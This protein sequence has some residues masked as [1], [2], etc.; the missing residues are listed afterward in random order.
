MSSVWALG[1]TVV[2][3]LSKAGQTGLNLAE[4]PDVVVNFP[5]PVQWEA[6][7]RLAPLTG[8]DPVPE[9][10]RDRCRFGPDKVAAACLTPQ[11]SK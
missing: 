11:A 5:D 8:R 4:R 6:V 9:S 2:L 1:D 10:K 7:E 3:G